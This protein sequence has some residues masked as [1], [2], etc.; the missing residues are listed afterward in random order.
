MRLFD[1]FALLNEKEMKLLIKTLLILAIVVSGSY[2]T[3]SCS[4]GSLKKTCPKQ[5]NKPAATAQIAEEDL[6]F[7]QLSSKLNY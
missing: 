4:I 3:H 6:G 1:I 5:G 7:W 2:T